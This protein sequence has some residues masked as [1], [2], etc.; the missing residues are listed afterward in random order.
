[1]EAY[2]GYR[3]V[4]ADFDGL[5]DV[6]ESTGKAA[7]LNDTKPVRQY[8]KDEKNA[9]RQEQ[10]WRESLDDAIVNV[11][12]YDNRRADVSAQ[13]GFG[14]GS[15]S[16]MVETTD[17]TA[18]G[19]DRFAT[20]RDVVDDVAGE[21]KTSA[22][23]RRVLNG[24]AATSNSSGYAMLEAKKYADAAEYFEMTAIIR[25]ESPPSYVELARINAQLGDKGKARES[26][27]TA[28]AKGFNDT[29]RIQQLQALVA[30]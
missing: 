7:A 21:S 12:S 2:L 19:T 22:S 4:T 30:P 3:A 20:L 26:L 28:I 16:D 17:F 13:Q 10:R 25:P 23:A 24:A 9:V 1:M 27:Q 18:N 14:G 5:A 11:R 15:S 29:A 6:S 8:F